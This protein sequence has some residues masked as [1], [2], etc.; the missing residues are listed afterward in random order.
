MDSGLALCGSEFEPV[1]TVVCSEESI[2]DSLDFQ[3]EE[4]CE[5]Q[6]DD[7]ADVSDETNMAAADAA[8]PDSPSKSNGVSD[9]SAGSASNGFRK[10]YHMIIVNKSAGCRM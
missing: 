10:L 6:I 9:A 1:E 3:E 4:Y 2:R 7:Q 5:E 8:Q